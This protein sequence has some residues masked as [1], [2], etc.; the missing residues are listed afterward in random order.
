MECLSHINWGSKFE[1]LFVNDVVSEFM[2]TVLDILSRFVPNKI[3]ICNDKGPPWNTPEITKQLN[4]NIEFTT[5]MSGAVE[6]STSG[7]M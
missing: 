7:R 3:A 5:N 4:V 6:G 2:T 1:N